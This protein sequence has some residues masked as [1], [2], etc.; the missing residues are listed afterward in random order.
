MLK[1]LER[2]KGLL[3]DI[4]TWNP[5]YAR[6]LKRKHGRKGA[7]KTLVTILDRND[8]LKADLTKTLLEQ[9]PKTHDPYERMKQEAQAHE[10]ASELAYEEIR[11]LYNPPQEPNE[12]TQE[13]LQMLMT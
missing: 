1:N 13:F 8:K 5:Q 7:L 9:I 3:T 6:E 10:L 4:E 11:Q 2:A 12:E